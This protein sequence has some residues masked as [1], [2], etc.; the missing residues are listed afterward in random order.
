M[1][2]LALLLSLCLLLLR[3]AGDVGEDLGEDHDEDQL[4]EENLSR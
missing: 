2:R 3:N 4:D 1:P